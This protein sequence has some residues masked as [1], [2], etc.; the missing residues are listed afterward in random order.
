VISDERG[1]DKDASYTRYCREEAGEG[2]PRDAQLL[3]KPGVRQSRMNNDGLMWLRGRRILG[4]RVTKVG[5]GDQVYDV[6]WSASKFPS[7]EQRCGF[8]SSA[9]KIRRNFCLLRAR[10]TQK[11]K[12]EG[13][14]SGTP[15]IERGA[16]HP[17]G[18]RHG[19]ATNAM[20]DGIEPDTTHPRIPRPWAEPPSH[21]T[22]TRTPSLAI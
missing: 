17:L 2:L 15:E 12:G 4:H 18:R 22:I 10:V 14:G 1:D 7:N 11:A 21:E 5:D 13:G 6:V 3:V 19:Q 8:L 9:Q 20:A 16:H